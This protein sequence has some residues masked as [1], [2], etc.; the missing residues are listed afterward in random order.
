MLQGRAEAE[1]VIPV[2]NRILAPATGRI[3]PAKYPKKFIVI[4]NFLTPEEIISPVPKAGVST[5]FIQSG[6]PLVGLVF[7]RAD[8]KA[9]A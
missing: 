1:I 3:V 6:I 5:Y 8:F 9:A 7:F 2:R 4:C